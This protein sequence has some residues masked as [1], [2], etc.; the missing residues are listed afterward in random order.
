MED[1]GVFIML[2]C[3]LA[4]AGVTIY[5][6]I[7]YMK[8]KK[9]VED[10]LAI[11]DGKAAAALSGLDVEKLDRM[12]NVKY[13]VDQVNNV[14]KDIYSAV[15]SNTTN[16]NTVQSTQNQMLSGLGSFLSFSSNTTLGAPTGSSTVP[17][18]NLPGSGNVDVNLMRRVNATMGLTATDL[19]SSK[20]VK[21]C[22]SSDPTRCIQIPDANGNLYLTTMTSNQNSTI[23][24]DAPNVRATGS[25]GAN[26]YNFGSSGTTG[27]NSGSI[28][29]QADGTISISGTQKIMLSNGTTPNQNMITLDPATNSVTISGSNIVL[30]GKTQIQG[31]LC[32][33]DTCINASN[34]AAIRNMATEVKTNRINF[35]DKW[36]VQPEGANNTLVFRDMVTGGDHRYAMQRGQGNAKNL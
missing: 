28:T 14:N 26:T 7:D 2:L 35:N 12:A 22:A 4:L 21:F 32:I 34:L 6:I 15:T 18:L 24:M 19:S 1:F 3:L 29:T 9:E 36:F 31:D 10:S 33:N 25:I 11:F 13:V 27:T 16:T 20:S 23:V 8:E 17:L 30:R 5:F